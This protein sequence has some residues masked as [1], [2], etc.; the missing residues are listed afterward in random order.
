ME[1]HGAVP[2]MVESPNGEMPHQIDPRLVLCFGEA[3]RLVSQGF[4]V[5]VSRLPNGGPKRP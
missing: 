3:L 4:L 1:L 2:E 5:F